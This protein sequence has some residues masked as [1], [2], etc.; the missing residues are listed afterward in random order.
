MC[1]RCKHISISIR[2]KVYL[3]V[4]LHTCYQAFFTYSYCRSLALTVLNNS[5]H[6][7]FGSMRAQSNWPLSD[8]NLSY[9]S[10]LI[11]FIDF[12]QSTQH[13]NKFPGKRIIVQITHTSSIIS[14]IYA[15]LLNRLVLLS[16]DHLFQLHNAQLV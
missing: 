15:K 8:L 3:L 1:A 12:N 5:E 14:I 16:R 7:D 4:H 13:S 2:I 6:T 9:I 10:T 11:Y